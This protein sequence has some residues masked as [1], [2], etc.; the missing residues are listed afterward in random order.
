ME[1]IVKTL[2]FIHDNW[3]N[4]VLIF[5]IAFVIYKRVSAF[6]SLS[7]EEKIDAAYRIIKEELL[8]YMCEAE[9]NWQA[10]EKAGLLKKSEVIT[11]IYQQFPILNEYVDQ[12]T[13]IKDI[14][15]M[16]KECMVEM[17]RI[18]NGIGA[19]TVKEPTEEIVMED[20]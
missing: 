4:I 17:N 19:E 12:E 5:A 1:G 15:D 3:T 18:I 2:T 8:K 20:K 7:K 16:I 11:K 13:L 6:L 14:S 9:V 10:F